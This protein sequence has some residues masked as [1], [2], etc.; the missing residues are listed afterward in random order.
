MATDPLHLVER[1]AQR[2]LRSGALDSSTAQLLDQ[3]A[4]RSAADPDAAG[5]PHPA[6]P[7]RTSPTPLA[8]ALM[9]AGGGAPPGALTDPPPPPPLHP[10]SPDD[11]DRLA[12]SAAPAPPL[13]PTAP[14]AGVAVAERPATLPPPSPLAPPVGAPPL[15]APPGGERLVLDTATFV[16]AGMIDWTRV[17]SR[18]SEELRLIQN[19][20]LRAAFSPEAGQQAHGNL[21]MITSARPG[22][23][24]SFTAVNLACSIA[25]QRD[26]D[27]LLVDLDSKIASTGDLLGL[28]DRPGLLDLALDPR[29]DSSTLMIRTEMEKLSVLPVGRQTERSGELFSTRQMS[30]TIRDLGR[31][32]A[33]RLVILDAPPALSSS[34]ASTLAPVVGQIVMVVEAERTQR[35]EVETAI[36]L[37]QAC[38]SIMLML[39]KVQV[40]QRHAF[41]FYGSHYGPYRG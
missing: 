39:N 38:P 25:R 14:G 30:R 13:T 8:D 9:L 31:R 32:Y 23:G 3:E 12:A 35:Q 10:L 7:A 1:A 34:D 6:A 4:A 40:A 37:L 27:V 36:E 15:A 33:D 24:K 17:R 22:E 19:Q 20:V 11:I 26:R 29:L 2:L 28:R 21:V 5:P 41:G 18:V 16:R